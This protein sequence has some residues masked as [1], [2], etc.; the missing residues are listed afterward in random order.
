[1]RRRWLV[2]ATALAAVGCGRDV[3][4]L[5]G[6]SYDDRFG[7]D[8]MDV[9]LPVDGATAR[10]A[11]MFIHG[12]GWRSGSR[13]HHTDHARRLAEAGYVT[14]TVDYRLVPAAAYPA[15]QQDAQCALAFLRAHASAWGL[16]PAR[17][18]VVGYSAGG[19]LVSLL[20]VASDEPD[21]QPDC[22]AGPTPPP[23][24]VI[25]GAGPQDIRIWTDIDSVRDM[26]GGSIDAVPERWDRLSPITHVRA[27]APPFLFI[28]GGSDWI[29]PVAQSRDMRDALVAAGVDA[30]LLELAGDG[31]LTG[32]GGAS[33]REDLGVISID[34]PEAW[35]ALTDFLA[36]TV[37][38]P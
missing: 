22:A 2:L 18:A 12:G 21:F 26:V 34:P 38:T 10:P 6:V 19:H 11:V 20:G 35:L 24:A 1:M 23:E 36:D 28:H 13:D 8:V 29:V 30:R 4:T 17:V 3:A 27:D 9:Y 33:G 7:A 25:S 16:D 14:A 5:A 15:Q 37:G 31:H 32:V